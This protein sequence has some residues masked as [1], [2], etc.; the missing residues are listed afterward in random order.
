MPQLAHAAAEGESEMA[1]KRVAAV[2]FFTMTM[3][4]VTNTS[5]SV[6]RPASIIAR[7]LVSSAC[8]Y[9]GSSVSR[10]M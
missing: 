10:V 1:M 9:N 4:G 6:S 2:P 3:R 7:R 8:L 5:S